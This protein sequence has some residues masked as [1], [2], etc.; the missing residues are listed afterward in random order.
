MVWD[1]HHHSKVKSLNKKIRKRTETG[2]FGIKNIIITVA[3]VILFLGV[4]LVYY[5][6]LYSQT[7]EKIIK[8]QE[9]SAVTEA[10]QIDQYLST[11]IYSMRFACFTLDNMIRDGESQAEIEE[12]MNNQSEAIVN[13]MSGSSNGMY[14]YIN[15]EFMDGTGWKPEDGFDP[16]VRPWYVDARANIGRVAIV[17]PYYDLESQTITISLSKT[18]CDAVSVAAMDVSLAYM[19]ELTESLSE[20]SDS[21]LDM[22]LDQNFTVITHSDRSEIGKNYLNESGTFGA[23]LAEKLHSTDESYFSL[24]QG[25]SDYIVYRVP[26]ANDWICVSVFDATSVFRQM[27]RTL[28]F[29]IFAACLVVAVILLI[30]NLLSRETQIA[31]QLESDIQQKDDQLKKISFDTYRDPLTG[32]K[33]KA[34]LQKYSEELSQK[35]K[36]GRGEPFSVLMMDVNN[37]KYINDNFGHEAGDDYLRGC[38]LTLC[39]VFQHSPVFRIGG[40]EF[41]TVSQN[42]DYENRAALFTKLSEAFDQA[43]SQEN[44]D[45]WKRYS[46]SFGTADNTAEDTSLDQVLKRADQLMYENKKA[47]KE[48]HGSYR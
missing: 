1:R 44:A 13:I 15:G 37:L 40:D 9:L 35:I 43:Y 17:D 3:I 4:L 7:R 2:G 19:Q 30:M 29:T 41:V 31:Q 14:G 34:A 48:K 28:L 5:G 33:N 8:S 42:D 23:A 46:A 20:Q 22:V 47:F 36:D 38:C 24:E 27:K 45:A 6:M 10:Q 26:M 18:L 32:V 11:G 16:T 12:F 39:H 21:D 25:D